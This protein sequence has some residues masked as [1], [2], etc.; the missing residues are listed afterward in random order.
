MGSLESGSIIHPWNVQQVIL[1]GDTVEV[2][3]LRD[4]L[5]VDHVQELQGM[6]SRIAKVLD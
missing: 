4:I 3:L 1:Q 5:H 2:G 6:D